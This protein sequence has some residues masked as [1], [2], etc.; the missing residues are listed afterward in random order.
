VGTGDSTV[1]S[2]ASGAVGAVSDWSEAPSELVVVELTA[3][4]DSAGTG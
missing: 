3:V 4:A 1:S 2:E